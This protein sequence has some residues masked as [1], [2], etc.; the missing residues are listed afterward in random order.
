MSNTTSTKSTPD[1]RND[2]KYIILQTCLVPSIICSLYTLVRLLFDRNLRTAI[3]NHTCLLLL[4]ISI[5][6]A[7]F[8]HPLT[9]NYLRTNRVTPSTDTTCLVWNFF[10]SIFVVS[11]YWT[12]AWGTIEKH[13]LIFAPTLLVTQ[14]NRFL[15]HYLPL[16]LTTFVYPVIA[17]MIFILF[18]PCQ[19]KFD[20]SSL[21]CAFPCSL[22]IRS[23]A[24]YTR[25]AHNFIPAFTVV[26]ATALLIMRVIKHKRHIRT[27][28]FTWRRYRR[29][30]SQSL[31]LSS[32]FLIL[33]LPATTVSIVQNCCQ[34]TFAADLQISVFNFLL[35]FLTI[36]MPFICLSSLPESQPKIRLFNNTR[37][38]AIITQRQ[39]N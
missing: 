29:M 28:R 14:R 13:I 22:S 4:V 17:A 8:N 33:T 11:T 7:F 34:A 16:F 9:L 31:S 20:M 25:F 15:L 39:Q 36:F 2:I 24:L 3:H 1:P 30:V 32:L 12:M 23:V 35:R 6:D 19:N 21:Y 5:L 27:N 38:R 26:S 10:N 18:Y 37:I